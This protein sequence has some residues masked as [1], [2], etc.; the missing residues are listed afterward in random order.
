VNRGILGTAGV[1]YPQNTLRTAVH[2]SVF[3][4]VAH[5]DTAVRVTDF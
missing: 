1:G 4:F 2:L 5:K 3:L